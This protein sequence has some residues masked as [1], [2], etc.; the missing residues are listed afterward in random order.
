MDVSLT[1]PGIWSRAVTIFGSE[2]KA[3]R[4]LGTKLSELNDRS[5]EETL[6]A[7]PTTE[8]VDAILDRI[9][10]GVFR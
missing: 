3:T 2:E 10:Y 6:R 7:D 1:C 9:E 8:A 4:W 5:P